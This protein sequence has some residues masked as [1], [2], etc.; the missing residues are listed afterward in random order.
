MLA[1]NL[2]ITGPAFLPSFLASFLPSFPWRILQPS[3][4]NFR[5]CFISPPQSV[6]RSDPLSSSFDQTRAQQHSTAQRALFADMTRTTRATA[7][8]KDSGLSMALALV[9]WRDVS[10][11]MA[12]RLSL[13]LS[14][15]LP[16]LSLSLSLSRASPTSLAKRVL[17]PCFIFLH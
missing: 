2:S 15:S 5:A 9:C 1:L 16:P 3:T 17:S 13:P 7:D 4:S 6:R 14:L 11:T 10:S 8:A 12:T